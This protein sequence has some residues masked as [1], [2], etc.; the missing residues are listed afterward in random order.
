MLMKSECIWGWIF[1][2]SMCSLHFLRLLQ[3]IQ[4]VCDMINFCSHVCPEYQRLNRK[5][6]HSCAVYRGKEVR[7]DIIVCTDLRSPASSLTSSS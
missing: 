4:G 1:P 2:P 7:V 6:H 5:H 3:M